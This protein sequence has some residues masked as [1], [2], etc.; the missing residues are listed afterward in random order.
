MNALPSIV[1]D[2]TTKLTTFEIAIMPEG[3]TMLDLGWWSRSVLW[4]DQ[5]GS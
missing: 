3:S 5:V 4:G 1:P 2:Y